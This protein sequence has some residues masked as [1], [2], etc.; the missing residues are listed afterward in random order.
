MDVPGIH[1]YTVV[2][3]RVI[4]EKRH[5]ENPPTKSGTAVERSWKVEKMKSEDS[6]TKGNPYLQIWP[7]D[8]ERWGGE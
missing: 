5:E 3:R 6:D 8:Q 2:D 1:S 7:T 4:W